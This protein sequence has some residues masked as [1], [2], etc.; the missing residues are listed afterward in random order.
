MKKVK[1]CKFNGL[2][3]NNVK[4]IGKMMNR[5]ITE[6]EI[7]V[8]TRMGQT[9]A[10]HSTGAMVKAMFDIAGLS[11]ENFDESFFCYIDN[12]IEDFSDKPARY[13]NMVENNENDEFHLAFT[14]LM[15]CSE[16]GV[17][18]FNDEFPVNI[19]K[20]VFVQSVVYLMYWNHLNRRQM[21][22]T[23]LETMIELKGSKDDFISVRAWM[24]FLF[25][26]EPRILNTVI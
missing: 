6:A 22:N 1:S 19:Q 20:A 10:H 17:K 4:E 25:L 18:K 7:R 16:N 13:I 15:T 3:E 2:T 24:M 14:F 5:E 26:T 8:M 21:L 23:L 11:T 9:L 12:I